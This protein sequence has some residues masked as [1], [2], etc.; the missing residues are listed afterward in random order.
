MSSAED[1]DVL[2]DALGA[3]DVADDAPSASVRLVDGTST[4]TIEDESRGRRRARRPRGFP[5][6]LGEGRDADPAHDVR[7]RRR[8]R[9]L[10]PLPPR[11]Q[12]RPVEKALKMLRDCLAW[13]EANDVD[14]SWTNRSTWRSSRRTRG[15]IR[16]RITRAD[17]LGR[18]VYIERTGS[19]KFADLVGRPSPPPSR[20]KMSAGTFG[21]P[22][23][24]SSSRPPAPTPGRSCPRCA[25][26]STSANCPSTTPC[27]TRRC[28]RCCGRSRRATDDYFANLGVTLVAHAPWTEF[29][30]RGA[31]SRCSWTRRPLPVQGARRRRCRGRREADEGA[32]RGRTR[33]GVGRDA[34]VRA[35][36]LRVLRSEGG[37]DPG[38]A[39]DGAGGVRE[40]ARR[41]DGVGVGDGE[42]CG[43]RTP[44]RGRE[45]RCA[46]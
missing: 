13:R 33:P 4:P 1:P 34:R 46:E 2:A 37:R 36:P 24:A 38:R 16:R 5:R 30:P 35:A 27:P 10:P 45:R 29:L 23:S 44:P 6:A 19:A 31:S 32:R 15:C 25:T 28:W 42:S 3:V 39:H 18:P 21:V 20:V 41:G 43:P 14:A 12:A 11:A 9:R 17:V 7:E 26:S 40:G 8:T 22:I